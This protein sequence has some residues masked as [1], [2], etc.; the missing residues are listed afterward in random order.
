L[1]L[2]QIFRNLR[3]DSFNTGVIIASLTIGSVTFILIMMFLV[4]EL[5]TD[6]FHS[7]FKKIYALKCED[8]WIPGK[9]IYYCKAGS[10]EYL[11]ENFTGV[12]DYCRIVNS[13]AQKV[14]ASGEDRFDKPLIISASE[15]FFT[16]FSYKLL[17][18]SPEQ[19]L[20][21]PNSAVI[22]SEIARKYFG[23]EDPSGKIITLVYT[24]NSV[25]KV[26]SGVFEKPVGNTQLLFD[27]V[28]QA[29]NAD[30]RCY[31][32]LTET[33][34]KLEIEELLL[35]H[36]DDI[37]VI[38]TGTKGPYFLEPMASAYFDPA[39]NL[40]IEASRDKSD[41]FISL[42]I[43]IIVISIALFNYLGVLA[44]KY[45]KRLREVWMR[46]IHGSTVRNIMM[47]F[48]LESFIVII[49][50]FF[51]SL[52]L[53]ND[54][55]P[56][57]NSLT[58]S[59]MGVS[60][61]FNS[62]G[63]AVLISVLILITGITILYIYF[64]VK[65]N[66][67]SLQLDNGSYL[68]TRRI[69]FPVFNILQ[70][71]CSAGLLLCSA[72]I[73][74]QIRYIENRPIGLDKEIL[75]IKIPGQFKDKA[76]IFRDELLKQNSVDQVS[77]TNASPLLEHFILALKYS[78]GGTEKQY[79]PSGFGGDENFLRVLGIEIVKGSGFS[80]DPTF[81][82]GKCLVNESFAKQFPDI[83]LI[84]RGMP[85]N[86]KAIII[87]IV[88]D[89]HYSDLKREIEPAFVSYNPN[90]YHLLVKPIKG[91]EPALRESISEIWESLIPG[92]PLNIESVHERFMW[93]H[94]GNTDFMKLIGSSALVSI[95][96]S[97]VGLFAV[98]HQKIR[99]RT[100]EIGIRKINGA[101]NSEIFGLIIRDFFIWTLIAGLISIPPA[102]YAINGW[103]SNY[104]Y[105]TKPGLVIILA[106]Q[107]IVLIISLGTVIWQSRSAALK[108]PVDVLRY[109]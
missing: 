52:V 57:F 11:K 75:E 86:E 73:L 107:I 33:S 17:S 48:T 36:K 21:A 1:K 30:G 40:T 7:G 80:D 29:G 50:S 85:G 41:L 95:F 35:K 42:T 77:V 39:R 53:I 92:Y 31:I 93:Y 87:G 55:L 38:N 10:A 37:P 62:S 100:K 46:R 12:E 82:A 104:A 99:A 68:R 8:P 108:N 6:S 106:V 102:I 47:L 71:A 96:L 15:N 59:N 81:N 103:L 3:R 84:G 97:M 26:I 56:F 45:K 19:V 65:S 64:L 61:F 54:L 78:E 20:S 34:G 105:K 72:V 90:G 16:F 24:D 63:I 22:S 18:G 49:L 14:I 94:R 91:L 4:R 32:K 28:C 27:I 25:E 66:L 101:W 70:I 13:N 88:K 51:L 44:N 2:N 98:S 5:R 76:I 9:M 69:S 60:Y 83:D 23:S 43:G 79:F 109:E 58:G 74:K 67:L 89:F